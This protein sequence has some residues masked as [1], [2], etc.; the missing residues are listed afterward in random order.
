[1]GPY[2]RATTQSTGAFFDMFY[3]YPILM[4]VVVAAAGGAAYYFWRK[5]D[6]N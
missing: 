4:L 3:Q 6:K 2:Y 1:M 5:K